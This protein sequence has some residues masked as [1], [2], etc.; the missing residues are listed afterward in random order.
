MTNN[1]IP[2]TDFPTQPSTPTTESEGRLSRMSWITALLIAS[3]FLIRIS[4]GDGLFTHLFMLAM[5]TFWICMPVYGILAVVSSKLPSVTR[6]FR[7]LWV[8]LMFYGVLALS[9]LALSMPVLR[10]KQLAPLDTL[11]AA[12]L[13]KTKQK[14]QINWHGSVC[15]DGWLSRSKGQ[16]TCSHHGGI[17]YAATQA[18]IRDTTS[19]STVQSHSPAECER[20]ARRK[21]WLY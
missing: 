13:S 4:D 10:A 16:G 18:R 5:G 9:V 20:F 21:S 15:N 1:Q 6:A 11:V 2:V 3:M 12:C 19:Y 17:N 14:A 7:R 8:E